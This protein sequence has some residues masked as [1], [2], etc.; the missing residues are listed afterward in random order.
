METLILTSG[1][2]GGHHSAA[3]AMKETLERAG[4][5]VH[6]LDPYTLLSTKTAT[7]INETY[8]TLVREAPAVFGGIYF[9]AD[10]Y[11]KVAKQSPVYTLNQHQTQPLADYLVAN[12]IEVVLATHLFPAEIMT[13]LKR[14]QHLPIPV[15]YLATDYACI[16]F[17]E[18]TACDAYVIAHEALVPEFTRYGLPESKL[19]PLGIPT[20]QAFHAIITPEQAKQ[21]LG[22]NA[23]HHYWFLAGGTIGMKQMAT[24]MSDLIH[25]VQAQENTQLIILTGSKN[26]VFEKL[27]ARYRNF[28]QVI[29]QQ[30]TQN[31]ELYLAASDYFFS[32]PGGLSSTEALIMKIP[33]IH[34]QP[35]PGVE[36]KNQ[37]FFVVHG[38]SIAAADFVELQ[39]AL[40]YLQQ[41]KHRK[42]MVKQQEQYAKPG[43]NQAILALMESL[44]AREKTSS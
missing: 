36:T 6:L 3:V 13:A 8:L 39:A 26:G 18:E 1:T 34:V 5:R 29:I 14:Q 21:K 37:E 10:H 17:T 2:G 40:V 27:Q 15:V 4:H 19:Y 9:L 28:P 22:L 43:A 32:K 20:R 16:P 25:L 44:V 24:V 41:E 12:H 33:L 7:F 35:I 31:I 23:D 30:T 42:Q 38:L 11:R